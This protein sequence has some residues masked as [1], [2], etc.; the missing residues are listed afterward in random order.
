MHTDNNFP[1]ALQAMAFLG[2]AMLGGV[3]LL[4]TIYGAIRKKSWTKRTLMTLMAGAGIYLVLVLGF[5]ALSKE[6][7]LAH[8]QEK[9]FCEIDCHL[10]YSIVDTKWGSAGESRALAVTIRT[11]FDENTISSHRPKDA[12]LAPSARAVTVIDQNGNSYL[13]TQVQG[14]P[15]AKELVPGES[16]TTTFEFSVPQITSGLRLLIT[17]PEGPVRLLIG[18]EMSVGH[19]K[20]YFTL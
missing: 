18:N 16:Y 15:L 12:P 3:L 10:A 8:G 5:S 9:Y 17:A 6:A 1:A 14:T 11:R 4:T 13:P 2:A 7:T 20:T 19:K